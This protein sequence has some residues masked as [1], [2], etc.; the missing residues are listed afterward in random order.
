MHKFFILTLIVFLVSACTPKPTPTPTLTPIP[1]PT[2]TPTP[3]PV[4]GPCEITPVNPLTV[5]VL[6]SAAADVFGT[7]ASETVTATAKTADGFYGFDPGVAQAGNS[8]LYRL[9]WVLKT[10]DLTTT[11]GCASIPT[12]VGPIAGLCYAM[13]MTDTPVYSSAD[14]ASSVLVTLHNGAFVMVTGHDTGWFT[15]DLNVG[16]AGMDSIG[17]IQDSVIGGL[18]GACE[19]L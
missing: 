13:I 12:V 7:L 11:P 4:P 6:P 9:R 3:T 18:K 8:G 19:G 16:T 1:P 10:H 14:A 17:H 15:T 5:Y 2:L